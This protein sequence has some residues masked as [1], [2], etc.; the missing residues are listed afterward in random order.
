MGCIPELKKLIR[1]LARKSAQLPIYTRFQT[2]LG[3]QT[4][5]VISVKVSH[6]GI[7]AQI[8]EA[9]PLQI[10]WDDL[11]DIVVFADSA[12]RP[13]F[14]TNNR[15]LRAWTLRPVKQLKMNEKSIELKVAA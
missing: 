4:V 10:T 8:A 2:T 1:L 14:V 15:D 6:Q 11:V 5:P 9:A 7:Q 12:G 13:Y 3:Y